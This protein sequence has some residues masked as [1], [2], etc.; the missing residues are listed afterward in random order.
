M[1]VHP[2]DVGEK[3]KHVVS[4]DSVHQFVIICTA[5]NHI[6][7]L[8]QCKTRSNSNSKHGNMVHFDVQCTTQNM[9]MFGRFWDPHFV[10]RPQVQGECDLSK[11]QYDL[12]TKQLG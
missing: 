12:A 10:V 5:G 2:G 11:Y 6:R 9:P 1:L 7:C 3:N 8:I 4:F